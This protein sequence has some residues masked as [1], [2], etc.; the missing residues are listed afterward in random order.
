MEYRLVIDATP[1]D[2]I[3]YLLLADLYGLVGKEGSSDPAH[4]RCLYC[5]TLGSVAILAS[6]VGIGRSARPT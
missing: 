2:S 6:G 4:R 1:D 3:E 5:R